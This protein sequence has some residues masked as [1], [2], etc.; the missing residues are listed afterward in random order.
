MPALTL[1]RESRFSQRRAIDHLLRLSVARAMM[2][3]RNYSHT[4]HVV[5]VGG[6]ISRISR[7]KRNVAAVRTL[8]NARL[9]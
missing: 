9:A 4:L 2:H 1:E 3:A 6:C 5:V 8:P 7:K